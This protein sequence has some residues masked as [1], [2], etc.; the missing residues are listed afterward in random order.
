MRVMLDYAPRL[1]L[2]RL[3]IGVADELRE[4]GIGRDQRKDGQSFV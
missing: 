1:R 3:P 2:E 4:P